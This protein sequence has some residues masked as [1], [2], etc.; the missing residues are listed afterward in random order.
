MLVYVDD[1]LFAS[2]TESLITPV[3]A[4]LHDLFTLNDLGPAKYFLGLEGLELARSSAGTCVT[5]CKY[6]KEPYRRLVGHLLHLRLTRL[7]VSY[8]AEELSQFV[9]RPCQQHGRARGCSFLLITPFNSWLTV[10][11]IGR[12][13]WILDVL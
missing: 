4:Y 8:G 10:M 1:V 6:V 5:Q 12:A 11:R 2:P 3:K 7:D 13:A 9:H